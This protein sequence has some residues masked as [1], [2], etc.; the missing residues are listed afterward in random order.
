MATQVS[1]GADIRAAL[2]VGSA[3][4]SIRDAI[5]N[6][7]PSSLVR[8][9]VG[10]VETKLPADVLAAVLDLLED[11]SEGREV[12][13]APADLLIGTQEASRLLGV[14]RPWLVK[15]IEAGEVL[16][17]KVGSKRRIPLG[18]LMA[19]RRVR[20]RAQREAAVHLGEALDR[21]QAPNRHPASV[22]AT[23]V[24]RDGGRMLR[25]KISRA[26]LET[27]RDPMDA[28]G[29]PLR[30]LPAESFELAA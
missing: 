13:V 4:D 30:R 8:V 17:E 27:H 23:S 5:R 16:A 14:S 24:Q 3:A 12:T 28:G 25:G 21:D 6:V 9:A 20:S 19:H 22:A 7:D 10:T 1:A 15:L 2:A 18:A 26:R 11:I 29:R